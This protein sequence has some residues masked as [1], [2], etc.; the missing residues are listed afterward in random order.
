MALQVEDAHSSLSQPPWQLKIEDAPA[1]SRGQTPQP[2]GAVATALPAPN[3]A[4]PLLYPS[5]QH[6]PGP[7][8]YGGFQHGYPPPYGHVIPQTTKP[9]DNMSSDAPDL[10]DDPTIYPTTRTWLMDLDNSS[11]GVDGHYFAQFSD[12]LEQNGYFTNY[13]NR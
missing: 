12:A 7:A 1:P 6:Y 5:Q 3:H 8:Y 9:T 4:I 2:I 13:P 10:D 11:H